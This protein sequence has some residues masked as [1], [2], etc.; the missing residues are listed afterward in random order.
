MRRFT[1]IFMAVLAMIASGGSVAL[2]AGPEEIVVVPGMTCWGLAEEYTGDGTR[3][4]ELYATN[5][6]SI[7]TAANGRGL[8]SSDNCHWIFPPT[9]VLR[10]PASWVS[11]DVVADTPVAP[12]ASEQGVAGVSDAP[13][14][15]GVLYDPPGGVWRFPNPSPV[16][17]TAAADVVAED[18]PVTPALVAAAGGFSLW[19]A[20]WFVGV[21]ILLLEII[22]ILLL[23]LVIMVIVLAMIDVCR[24]CRQRQDDEV[25]FPAETPRRVRPAYRESEFPVAVE[26]PVVAVALEEVAQ[27]APSAESA[28]GGG[29]DDAPSLVTEGGSSDDH[30]PP[31]PIAEVE[32]LTAT[33]VITVTVVAP[34]TVTV[35]KVTITLEV[36]FGE[37]EEAGENAC[38]G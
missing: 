26:S 21:A 8:A 1:V 24:N 28:R 35:T 27:T 14:P 2:A 30:A 37:E 17:A 4:P 13:E 23:L 10:L 7:E 16:V 12:T 3:W 33:T 31:P 34:V 19:D 29:G 25:V 6:A 18:Q 22:A 38:R 15:R 9:M 36:E 32:P 5:A 20:G 11:A